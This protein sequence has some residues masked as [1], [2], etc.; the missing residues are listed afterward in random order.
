MLKQLALI[1]FLTSTGSF[2]QI[3]FENSLADAFAKAKKEH[4][5]VFIEFYNETCSVCKKVNPLLDTKE[6]GDVY[7]ALFASYKINT[8][9]GINEQDQAF[10]DNHKLFFKD[11]PNFIY[12][13]ADEKFLHYAGG[14]ADLEYIKYTAGEA[15][16]P[17]KQT[18]TLAQ[19]IA[20]GDKSVKTLY[21]YSFLAQLHEDYDLVNKI[22]DQ[23][24]EVFSKDKL[25]NNSSFYILKNSVYT[26]KNGFFE[27][28]VQN[29]QAFDNLD[30]GSYKGKE[31]DVLKNIISIDITNSKLKWDEEFLEKMHQYMVATDYS[32]KPEILLVEKR[33]PLLDIKNNQT[34]LASY[35]EYVL[36]NTK[37][38]LEDKVYILEQIKDGLK[39]HPANALLKKEAKKLTDTTKDP[40]LLKR[41]YNLSK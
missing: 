35:L 18:S 7:N 31:V 15:L 32:S 38:N 6:V 37:Y 30:S 13:S 14:K 23:I 4:K 41:L 17:S 20:K 33:L 25:G 2:A 24:F 10:L 27:F 1:I 8:H 11:V 3:K 28:F 5:N 29:Q 22:A 36:E 26:T 34:K 19:R 12:F 39:K 40:E 16:N 21:E 9:E